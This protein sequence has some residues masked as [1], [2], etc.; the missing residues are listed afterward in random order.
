MTSALGRF[1]SQ[2]GSL[3]CFLTCVI[4]TFTSGDVPVGGLC[5]FFHNTAIETGRGFKLNFSGG[6]ESKS[7]GDRHEPNFR[8][9]WEPSGTNKLNCILYNM[10]V[11]RVFVAHGTHVPPYVI[12]IKLS[13]VPIIITSTDRT[14]IQESATATT[15][16]LCTA[17]QSTIHKIQENISSS[18]N[19]AWNLITMNHIVCTIRITVS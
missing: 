19:C 10:P 15:A 11:H 3:A 7:F 1:R 17:I 12:I 14:A 13:Q 18:F 9:N 5:T 4:L 2:G 16:A 8:V 6:A